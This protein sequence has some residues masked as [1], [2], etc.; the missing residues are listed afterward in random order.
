MNKNN[1]FKALFAALFIVMSA[2]AQITPNTVAP[3]PETDVYHVIEANLQVRSNYIWRGFKVSNSPI[4]N[5]DLHYISRNGSF[6]AGFWGGASFDGTY[7]E[8]DY[9]ASYTKGNFKAA[10]WDINNFSNYPDADI[11]DY[12]NNTTS[13]FVDVGIAYT[14]PFK[15]T[16]LTLSWNT[17][18][19]GRDFHID[20]NGKA[21]NNYS[22]Y[23]Q[24]DLTLWKQQDRN[25]HAVVAGAF[26]FGQEVHF[27]GEDPNL[28]NV[29]LV[30]NQ[31]V[32]VLR[33]Y[34]LPVSLTAMFN[35]EKKIGALQV[36][37][38]LF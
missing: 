2:N 16:P 20:E 10:I 38:S 21:T 15:K 26:A 23:V 32:K 17:I 28:V 36:V 31:D 19:A 3:A 13:H 14:I 25:L 22:H 7:K 27:Y 18:V 30:Y 24:A 35:P 12:K 11:F 6:K 33:N 1:T 4:T 37:A 34:I 8:F 9:Y 29:G 5:A